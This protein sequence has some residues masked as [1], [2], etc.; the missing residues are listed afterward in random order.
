MSLIKGLNEV[1][2]E[3]AKKEG[4]ELFSLG[5][6]QEELILILK[7][8]VLIKSSDGNFKIELGAF[9]FFGIDSI[10]RDHFVTDFSAYVPEYT[11]ILRIKR[12]D[13][14]KAISCVDNFN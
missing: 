9:K 5:Q 6:V 1:N 11:R 7:G 12:V 3:A 13:Y 14:L 4:F 10:L 8:K 2:E